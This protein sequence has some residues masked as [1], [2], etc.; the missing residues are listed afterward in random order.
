MTCARIPALALLLL[1]A[2]PALAV[3][4]SVP[5]PQTCESLKQQCLALVEKA[6]QNAQTQ[7]TPPD[8]VFSSPDVCYAAGDKA[9]ATGVWPQMGPVLGR[10]CSN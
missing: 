10:H 6:S 3:N 4:V 9:A 1:A 8:L 2:G 5:K 7:G